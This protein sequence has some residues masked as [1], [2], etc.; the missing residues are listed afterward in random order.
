MKA[1]LKTSLHCL[2]IG[3]LLLTLLLLLARY[4]W[5]LERL[6]HFRLPFAG[7]LLILLAVVLVARFW[8]NSLALSLCLLLQVIPLSFHY[9]PFTPD[10]RSASDTVLKVITFNV[11][12]HNP[13]K[14]EVLAYLIEEDADVICLQE[15]NREWVTAL[16]PLRNE[17]PHFISHPRSDNFGLLLFSKYP[18]TSTYLESKKLGTPH[19]IA[20]VQWQ[21]AAFTL[22]NAHPLPPISADAARTRNA[23]LDRIHRDSLDA[24]KTG[25]PLIA[26]GDFNCTRYSPAFA[27]LKKTLH[28]SSRGRGYPATW[29]RGNLL[30]GIPIDHLLH[31]SDF[32]ATSYTV[33]PKLGS[34]HS[35]VVATFHFLP[36]P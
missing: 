9:L 5:F 15:T 16:Q 28:D 7:G 20:E 19:L 31:T 35:P 30:L 33:G 12:T 2:T 23:T 18:F 34:D 11:L 32:V 3:A 22:I 29:Q 36:K 21:E 10:T 1:L 26:A 25:T 27:S 14:Q 17:Y 4:H 13:Q 24:I 6:T 8:K